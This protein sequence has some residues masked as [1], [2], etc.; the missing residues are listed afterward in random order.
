LREDRWLACS[1]AKSMMNQHLA[2]VNVRVDHAAAAHVPDRIYDEFLEAIRGVSSGLVVDMPALSQILSRMSNMLW[3]LAVADWPRLQDA[4]ANSDSIASAFRA[5]SAALEDLLSKSMAQPYWS[6]ARRVAIG[7]CMYYY[8]DL[9][10]LAG[11]NALVYFPSTQ[12]RV[13]MKD[14]EPVF[15][16][17]HRFESRE[18]SPRLVREDSI[19]QLSALVDSWDG[20]SGSLA[21]RA[22]VKYLR[23]RVCPNMNIFLD[24]HPEGGGHYSAILV[25][26][27]VQM[28]DLCRSVSP[29]GVLKQVRQALAARLS[30]S[31]F[32]LIPG[33]PA[34]IL[35]SI[36]NKD[37]AVARGFIPWISDEQARIDAG[38][39]LRSV[40]DA[41]NW[42][43]RITGRGTYRF[44]VAVE[45]GG[46]YGSFYRG[47]GRALGLAIRYGA[48]V[49]Q[50]RIDPSLTI[51]LHPRARARMTFEDLRAVTQQVGLL[52]YQTKD[53]R[54]V[55]VAVSSGIDEGLGPGGFASLSD[56]EWTHL[57]PHRV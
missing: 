30:G 14:M 48:K 28:L 51:A 10:A 56:T 20:A 55:L 43:V 25:K 54:R 18:T 38:I 17:R 11:E 35:D 9:K 3:S 32:A 27:G 26:F 39:A 33:L 4:F 50:L 13:L 29:P 5:Q 8:S 45:W 49:D 24:T 42:N 37:K 16:T 41:R 44:K 6:R 2:A 52:P 36:S 21:S 57:F 15:R 23:P 7:A 34:G 46:Q 22:K 19:A 1:A 47:L 40:A 53:L 31:P 12:V